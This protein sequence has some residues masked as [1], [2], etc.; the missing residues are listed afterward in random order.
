MPAGPQPRADGASALH[1]PGPRTVQIGAGPAAQTHGEQPPSPC[2]GLA[3]EEA[4]PASPSS[5]DDSAEAEQRYTAL[6]RFPARNTPSTHT[7]TPP[8]TAQLIR[9]LRGGYAEPGRAGH[10]TPGAPARPHPPYGSASAASVL[11][12][13]THRDRGEWATLV[14]G[15]S[16]P[17]DGER[18]AEILPSLQPEPPGR[19]PVEHHL[20]GLHVAHLCKGRGGVSPAGRDVGTAWGEQ[21]RRGPG[22]TGQEETGHVSSSSSTLTS[23][24]CGYRRTPNP[25]ASPAAA[26]ELRGTGEPDGRCPPSPKPGTGSSSQ[27][28]KT[29]EAVSASGEVAAGRAG[30]QKPFCRVDEQQQGSCGMP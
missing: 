7:H 4:S 26:P 19:R 29:P 24:H 20:V 10:S 8:A 5:Q 28:P 2:A 23:P 12:P 22:R 6:L 14:F 13:Q 25:S 1:K 18:H 11:W 9:R 30:N 21:P 27:H 17:R 16:Y 15:F 3:P